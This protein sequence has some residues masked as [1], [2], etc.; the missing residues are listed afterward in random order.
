MLGASCSE[1]AIVF[2]RPPYKRVSAISFSRGHKLVSAFRKDP[3][4]SFQINLFSARSVSVQFVFS[5][6]LITDV[7]QDAFAV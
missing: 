5:F 1:P 6:V 3:M 7:Q 4:G 2:A